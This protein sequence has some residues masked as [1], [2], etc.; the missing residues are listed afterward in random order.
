VTVFYFQHHCAVRET[1]PRTTITKTAS[2][3][4]WLKN[5]EPVGG[6]MQVRVQASNQYHAEVLSTP[7]PVK[8]LKSPP[9]FVAKSRKQH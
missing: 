1:Y 2:T 5:T 6:V 9:K 7:N 4:K 8:M 3:I